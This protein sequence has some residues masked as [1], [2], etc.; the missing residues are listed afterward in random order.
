MRSKRLVQLLVAALA[1]ALVLVVVCG[2]LHRSS[3]TGDPVLTHEIRDLIATLQAP[4]EAGDA[5]DGIPT[6]AGGTIRILTTLLALA[7]LGGA[8][9]ALRVA[10]RQQRDRN[11]SS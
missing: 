7:G 8:L 3:Q 2:R 5:T 1:V 11:R 6:A 9:W 4:L 10:R